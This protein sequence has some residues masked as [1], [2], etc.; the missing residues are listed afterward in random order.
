[1]NTYVQ[2]ISSLD[3]FDPQSLTPKD[4]EKTMNSLKQQLLKTEAAKLLL[5]AKETSFS[6]VAL[7]RLSHLL[8]LVFRPDKRHEP[9][10]AALRELDPVSLIMCGLSLTQKA[11]DV[12]RKELFD[13]LLEQAVIAS[14]TT[15]KVIAKCNEIN[16]IVMNSSADEDFLKS[17][18]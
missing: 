15:V 18:R 1:M 7:G 11:I 12:M 5:P 4:L 16:K 9:K 6:R 13:T 10:L 17:N 8:Q 2:M 14:Q 3:D